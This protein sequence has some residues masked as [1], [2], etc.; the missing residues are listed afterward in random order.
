MII[1]KLETE[2][3]RKISSAV[4]PRSRSNLHNGECFKT[5]QVLSQ[6]IMIAIREFENA[7]ENDTNIYL[8]SNF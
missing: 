5:L 7:L 2:E 6:A 8:R 3:I 4:N 1:I